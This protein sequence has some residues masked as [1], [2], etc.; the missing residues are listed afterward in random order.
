MARASWKEI[1]VL[2]VCVSIPCYISYGLRQAFGNQIMLI[3]FGGIYYGARCALHHCDPY[4]PNSMVHEVQ[5]DGGR[6][7]N[8][9]GKGEEEADQIVVTRIFNL[10][11]AIFLAVPIALLPWGMAQN[12]WMISTAGLLVAAAF[13]IWDLGAGAAPMIWAALAGFMLADSHYLFQGG[14]IAGIVATTCIIAAWCF[15]K[16]RYVHA[17]VLLFAISLV[18]KPHD[19]GFV[20]LYFVLAGGA[21][22]KR[23]LQTF[24]VAAVLAVCAA[25]WIAPA[26]PHWIAEMHNNAAFSFAHGG[27]SDPGPAGMTLLSLN[28]LTNLQAVL[29]FFKDDPHF[30]NPASYFICGIL[31]LV[32]GLNALRKRFSMENA[33]LALAAISA[34]TLLPVYHRS[35]DAII[36]LLALPAC[37]MLWKRPG[38]KRWVA[39]GLTSGGI[40]LT[41]TTP[42]FLLH[43]NAMVLAAFAAKIGRLPTVLVLRPAPFVLLAMGCFYLWLYVRYNAPAESPSVEIPSATPAAVQAK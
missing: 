12:L 25:I 27:T 30:Y 3:D 33:N 6:F 26:S 31:I 42:L 17:G 11:T 4:D 20:W 2:L 16:E 40:L 23:A 29:S 38:L 8:S 7:I 13:F 15:L 18:L 22:R 41:A 14:N 19:S 21:L 36:L 10:P 9:L 39:L 28:G 32:W 35:Y 34:L 43:N 24:T 5:A 37:A 1:A